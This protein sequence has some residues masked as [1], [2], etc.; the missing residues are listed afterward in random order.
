MKKKEPAK[1]KKGK[2]PTEPKKTT[3]AV[4]KASKKEP[5]KKAA[6]K[7]SKPT[8]EEE[9]APAATAPAATP[10]LPMVPTMER[11]DLPF[12]QIEAHELFKNLRQSYPD[13]DNLASSIL[14]RGLLQPLT[15]WRVECEPTKMPWGTVTARYFL[16]AGFCRYKA[17]KR[18]KGDQPEL[19]QDVPVCVFVGEYP[20]ARLVN[21]T[22]NVQRNNLNPIEVGEGLIEL[23]DKF[24]LSQTEL[25]QMLGKSQPWVSQTVSFVKDTTKVTPELKKAVKMNLLPF[26][27]AT[28]M[29][30]MKKEVQL[31]ICKKLEKAAENGTLEDEVS[32][33]KKK[34]RAATR[35]VRTFT[36]LKQ[37]LLKWGKVDLTTLSAEDRIHY[38]G[39][40]KGLSFALNKEIKW[41]KFDP[42]EWGFDQEWIED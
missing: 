20:E 24:S 1:T 23:E 9:T 35:K 29:G 2:E 15:V 8:P 22:E 19:F 17:I 41:D 36:E 5:K 12:E 18:I 27:L 31:A 21:M 16:I 33:A 11:I 42:E 25:G 6:A 10:A 26:W 40:L 14:Q 3:K 30:Q 38:S 34:V 13:I 7:A 32:K 28:E 4:A 39:I 37:Q